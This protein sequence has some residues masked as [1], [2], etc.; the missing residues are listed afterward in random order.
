MEW[1]EQQEWLVMR[2]FRQNYPDLPK[3]KLEKSESP[4]FRLWTTPR[5]FIGIEITQAHQAGQLNTQ[6]ILHYDTVLIQINESVKAKE[7]KLRLYRSGG[8]V[9]VW[10]IIF[11]DYSEYGAFD[12][13]KKEFS[14]IVLETSFDKVFLFDLD[15]QQTFQL[16]SW[17]ST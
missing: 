12:K 6:G 17:Q 11:S 14:D 13:V 16:N 3:G 4:D 5:R 10:L 7:S 2:Y 15:S 1:K 8:P 9:E